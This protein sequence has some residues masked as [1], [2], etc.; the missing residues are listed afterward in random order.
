M[1]GKFNATS[2]LPR[3]QALW[4]RL[5]VEDAR[6]AAAGRKVVACYGEK[7][8]FYHAQ[9]HLQAVLAQL[10]WAR[11]ALEK[12]GE[13]AGLSPARKQRLFDTVELALWYHDIVYDPKARDN[14]E[15]SRDLFL[16]DAEKFGLPAGVRRDVAKLIDLTAHHKD[17]KSLMECLMVDCDLAVLGAKPAVFRQYDADIRREYAHVEISLYK[18]ARKG[19]LEGFLD[20][21]SV[22]RTEAFRRKLEA[23]AQK[24]LAEAVSCLAETKRGRKRPGGSGPSSR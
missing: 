9:D 7:G 13:L 6:L 8:R 15:Q 12:S 1:K 2:S 11:A 19:V 23:Q 18:T 4:G 14:E 10:D 3:W 22:F 17:A 21:P 20:Q 24:N 5:G 16:A